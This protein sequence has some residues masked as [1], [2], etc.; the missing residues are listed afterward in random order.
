MTAEPRWSTPRT[1]SRSTLGGIA[2]NIAVALG[3]PL[4]E[5]QQRVLDVGLEQN[6]DGSFA[7][8]DV[9]LTVPRQNGK[10]S[11][12]L[13][14]A[15]TRALSDDGQSIK[16]TAQHGA[17]ARQKLID[18]WLPMLKKSPLARYFKPRLTSGHEALLFQNGSSL[19]L[20]AT[21][22]KSGHG[23]TVDLGILDESF[24]HPD[25]RVEQSIRPAMLTRPRA[26]LWVVSTAGTM[27]LSPYLW[28]KVEAGR[29]LVE[30]G[31]TS[32]SAYF[33]W[34]AEDDADPGDPATWWSCMPALGHT[35]TEAVVA[36][37]FAAM[38]TSEFQRAMLNR[39]VVSTVD[40]VIPLE[41]WNG[42]IDQRSS[43]DGSIALAFDVTPDRSRSAIAVAGHRPDGRSHL[44]V[45][46]HQP[47]TGWVVDRVVE[48]V[49]RH[50]PSGVYCDA[51]GP[52]GSLMAEIERA[53]VEVTAISGKEHAQA[54]GLLYD[55]ATQGTMRHLGTLEL[56][57][58]L[59]GAV[60]R[61][62]GD[63]WA[64]SRKSSSVDISPLV[65]CTI[66]LWGAQT[67]ENEGP[68]V[69]NL[70]DIVAELRKER[71]LV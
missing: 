70:N 62:L 61:P 40:P 43:A 6:E 48:L 27:A 19:G 44:E 23:S 57:A 4:M 8:R 35:I 20:V 37:D 65:A 31:V 22:E 68:N 67:S 26:Q 14:L 47:G 64:W 66:A 5:W 33:E 16:Y 12:L 50:R 11:L 3:T 42:L 69:W 52:A 51:S 71:G 30:A 29:Q 18:D 59:D 17:A 9:T 7:Y 56:T 1:P 10:S 54:C 63:A 24:A 49:E 58:A 55:A 2:G 28:G 46:D 36:A 45:V 15:M 60:K 53:G 13:V 21:T 32:S 34:S 41:V 39:W 38:S 25:A